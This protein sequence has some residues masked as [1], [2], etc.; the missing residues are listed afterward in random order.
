MLAVCNLVQAIGID[1]LPT[2]TWR[3]VKDDVLRGDVM[4][5]LC[6]ASPLEVGHVRRAA[7]PRILGNNFGDDL[8]QKFKPQI[9][10]RDSRKQRWSS[11]IGEWN[12]TRS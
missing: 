1:F 10:L 12:L 4:Q 5:L 7:L 9:P 11:L 6:R 3:V 8:S 2:W